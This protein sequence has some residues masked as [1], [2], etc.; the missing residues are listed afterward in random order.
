MRAFCNITKRGDTNSYEIE[1]YSDDLRIQALGYGF[2]ARQAYRK[3]YRSYRLELR[4]LV[5]CR[6]CN[7]YGYYGPYTSGDAITYCCDCPAGDRQYQIESEYYDECQRDYAD[8][9]RLFLK[10]DN[11]KQQQ[12]L[13]VYQP[14]SLEEIQETG[15]MMVASGYFPNVKSISQAGVKIMM[16]AELGFNATVSMKSIHIIDSKPTIGGD[17]LASKIKSS[18]KYRYTIKEHTT[19]ICSIDFYERIDSKWEFIGNSTFDKDDAQRA[20]LLRKT[21]WIKWPR[22]MYF[23]RAIAN[24]QRWF[25]PDVFYNAGT[26]YTPDELGADVDSDGHIIEGSYHETPAMQQL[27]HALD[28][29]AIKHHGPDALVEYPTTPAPPSI[30]D[31]GASEAIE[32]DIE[33]LEAVA[34]LGGRNIQGVRIAITTHYNAGDFSRSVTN[35]F[36]FKLA[37]NWLIDSWLASLTEGTQKTDT[38]LPA[39]L[40]SPDRLLHPYQVHACVD[41]TVAALPDEGT[42]TKEQADIL[43]ILLHDISGYDDPASVLAELS[44]FLFQDDPTNLLKAQARAMQGWLVYTDDEGKLISYDNVEEEITRI[45]EHRQALARMLEAESTETD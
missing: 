27:D 25:C 19:E 15:K 18:G 9:Q 14:K 40:L 36:L 22:N 10:G 33:L 8:A 23:N 17:L 16:G 30:D 28:D 11:M 24:G 42:V 45:L 31:T 29:V 44:Q 41:A 43:E 5:Y 37:S 38:Q 4:F 13:A 1:L 12:A 35:A 2:T 34:S 7:G 26:V 39:L 32:W 20:D 3:A 6:R 21:N